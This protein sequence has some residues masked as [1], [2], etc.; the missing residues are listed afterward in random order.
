MKIMTFNTQHCLNFVTRKI[1]FDVMAKAISACESDIVGLNEMRGLG[2]HKDYEAQVERLAALTGMKYFY[3]SKAIDFAGYGPYGNGILSKYPIL[4]AETVLVPD[5]EVRAYNG[6]YETRA[7]LKAELE[8]GITVLVTHMGLN[9]DEQNNA[10]ATVLANVKDSKCI[11]MGDFN[12]EPHDPILRPIFERM[13]DTAEKICGDALTFPSDTP[14]KKIDYVLT[15]RDA[16]VIS[17]S[18]PEIIAS[19]HRPHVAEVEF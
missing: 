3:F 11:L 18:V 14:I 1:D 13:S 17:A 4:S 10:V 6:Y 16:R 8:G 12:M 15:S 7:V 19:D 2:T 5:P 9:P